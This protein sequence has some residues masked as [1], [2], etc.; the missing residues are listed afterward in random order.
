MAQKDKILNK[1]KLNPGGLSFLEFQS[2]LSGFGWSK[3]RHKGSH[4]IWY[5]S[6]GDRMSIQNRHGTAKE[7]QVKQ[8]LKYLQEVRQ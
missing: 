6:T 2:L 1:A 3:D 8:F 5:S 4:E 7:Y